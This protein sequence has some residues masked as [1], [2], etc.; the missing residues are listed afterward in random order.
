[1]T[2][3]EEP[4]DIHHWCFGGVMSD[5]K[6]TLYPFKSVEMCLRYEA[7]KERV[8]G[9]TL[10]VKNTNRSMLM[11]ALSFRFEVIGTNAYQKET[12]VRLLREF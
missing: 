12:F 3:R 10:E 9:V 6:L 7:E 11:L 1:M 4:D 5:L 8:K 2:V